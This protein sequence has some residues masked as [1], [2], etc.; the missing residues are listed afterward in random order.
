M[1]EYYLIAEILQTSRKDGFVKIFS[2]SDFPARFDSLNRVFIEF[3][4]DMKLFYVEEVRSD[5][6]GLLLK[7]KNFDSAEDTQ[8]LVGKKVFVDDA[9]VVRLPDDTHFVH[10]LVD[11]K[12]FR[13]EE[14]VG[15]IKDVLLMPANDVYVV[16]TTADKEVLIPAL[17]ESIVQIDIVGK[18]MRLK[19]D[20]VWYDDED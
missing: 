10:D 5:K 20:S 13:G 3:F 12:V 6:K 4:G 14:Y 8:V 7:F 19:P 2:Y 9:D 15:V 1:K 11:C 17:K 16:S 18:V